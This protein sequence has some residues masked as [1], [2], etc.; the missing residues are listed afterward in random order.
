M[1]HALARGV[2]L[3]IGALFSI[4][5]HA[6]M[7]LSMVLTGAKMEV[8]MGVAANVA[9]LACGKCGRGEQV[10]LHAGK[11]TVGAVTHELRLLRAAWLET[12]PFGALARGAGSVLVAAVVVAI[13]LPCLV[14]GGCLLLATR[15]RFRAAVDR[16]R[17]IIRQELG[18]ATHTADALSVSGFFGVREHAAEQ[19]PDDDG[20]SWVDEEADT[21][22][23]DGLQPR[24]DG[25]TS[26]WDIFPGVNEQ[27][28]TFSSAANPLSNPL[29]LTVQT[30]PGDVYQSQKL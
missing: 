8:A 4:P 10:T 30:L 12:I 11:S 25:L 29:H 9:R 21:S 3:F 19:A 14:A 17:S 26:S 23:A 24:G 15:Q 16:V 6:A 20:V 27:E 2:L 22:A 1:A 28:R 13:G 5:L 18:T 7:L